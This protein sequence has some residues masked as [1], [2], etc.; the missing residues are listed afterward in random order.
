MGIVLVGAKTGQY[1]KGAQ[2]FYSM[3][4]VGWNKYALVRL[5]AGCKQKLFTLTGIDVLN[6]NLY[7]A[8]YNTKHLGRMFV[9]VVATYYTLIVNGKTIATKKMM[10]QR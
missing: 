4:M 1:G 9:V 5:A 7:R 2:A 10:K 6:Y 8:T 3:G